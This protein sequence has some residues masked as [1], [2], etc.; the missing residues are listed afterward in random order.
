MSALRKWIP[1]SEAY[2]LLGHSSDRPLRRDISAG[3]Y[4]ADYEDAPTGRRRVVDLLSLPPEA[5]ALYHRGQNQAAELQQED[6]SETEVE[7]DLYHRAPDW[8]RKKA[9]KYLALIKA[10]E[11][12]KG[13]KLKAFL[14]EWN[15]KHPELASSYPA[16]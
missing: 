1:V 15:V 3:K 13:E 8:A 16:L 9:D 7:L 12:L 10:S 5:Q 11:G 14:A 4:V 2:K 6:L